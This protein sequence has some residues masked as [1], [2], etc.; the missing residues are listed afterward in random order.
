VFTL[1]CERQS[2][3]I[4]QDREGVLHFKWA[5]KEVQSSVQANRSLTKVHTA[6]FSCLPLD[7]PFKFCKIIEMDNKYLL[8]LINL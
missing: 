8:G 2:K 1:G 3:G 4:P 7:T 5:G 6:A